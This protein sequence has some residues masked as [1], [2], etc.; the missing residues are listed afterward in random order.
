MGWGRPARPG[1]GRAADPDRRGV[2]ELHGV[3]THSPRQGRIGRS[4]AGP[5]AGAGVAGQGGR[6]EYAADDRTGGRGAGPPGP[7][8]ELGRRRHGGPG[9]TAPGAR[10]ADR[11]RRGP[12]RPGAWCGIHRTGRP[13]G[14]STPSAARDRRVPTANT[15]RRRTCSC[16]ATTPSAASIP[17]TTAVFPPIASWAGWYATWDRSRP[18]RG[19]P[20]PGRASVDEAPLPQSAAAAVQ[21]LG[22]RHRPHGGGQTGPRGPHPD[23]ADP[24]TDTPAITRRAPGSVAGAL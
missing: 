1:S 8:G 13:V 4:R 6:L 11:A 21:P 15:R 22:C 16:S 20:A 10:P 19:R 14:G 17:G 9:R 2:P 23:I 7:A 5:D 12:P 3:R 24:R 18:T